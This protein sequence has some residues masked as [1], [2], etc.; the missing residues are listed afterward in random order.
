MRGHGINGSTRPSIYVGILC[1][2]LVLWVSTRSYAVGRPFW[3]EG[4]NYAEVDEPIRVNT[5]ARLAARLKPAVVNISVS[6][7]LSSHPLV[8]KGFLDPFKEK[9]QGEKFFKK[10]MEKG[11]HGDSSGSG[12]IINRDGYIVTNHHVVEDTQKI[13]VKLSSGREYEADVV[14][15]DPKTDLALLKIN[16]KEDLPVA[17][18]GDSDKLQ[19]GEWVIAIGNPFG[20]EHS[21]TAGIV[22]AKGRFLGAS[23]YD[24]FIQTDA[25]INPGNS[26]GPL[27]NMQGYVVGINTAVI[28]Q[29]QGLGFAIPINLAKEIL[30][31]LKDKGRYIRGWLGVSITNVTDDMVKELKMDKARGVLVSGVMK[32]N[33]AY[34][35]GIKD[36]DVIVGFDGKEVSDARDLQRLVAGT[37][38]NKEV[39]ITVMRKGDE[40]TFKVV[41]GEMSE[42][43]FAL[44]AGV[45]ERLGLSLS[46]I[47]ARVAENLKLKDTRGVLVAEVQPD[48]P[49]QRAGILS[50]DVIKEVDKKQVAGLQDLR[51]LLE[52]SK[53][54][55]VLFLVERETEARYLVLKK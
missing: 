7:T 46:D 26:G 8:P 29:G 4:K 43:S 19:I 55:S 6:K 17:V 48:S 16:T 37:T 25:A 22:S 12:F 45:E 34:K 53:R 27:F 28:S 52:E 44:A 11:F 38:I 15:S 30:P 3:V 41:V 14:G 2:I 13:V 9:E 1:G 54:D 5:F 23:P 21:I 20:F 50:G 40:K 18:L 24:D 47:T 35:A 33:P 42:R 31:Q 39:P 32:D 10:R 36:G 49:A 51:R